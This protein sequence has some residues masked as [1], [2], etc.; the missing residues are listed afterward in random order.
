M[1]GDAGDPEALYRLASLYDQGAG[2]PRDT[3]RARDLLGQ[4]ANLGSVKAKE[5]MD[6]LLGVPAPAFAPR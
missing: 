6:A 1:A 5:R 4:A 2:V 3:V